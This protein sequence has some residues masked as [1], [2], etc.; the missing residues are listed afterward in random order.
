MSASAASLF[1]LCLGACDVT[2][3]TD[4]QKTSDALRKSDVGT[5]LGR[6]LFDPSQNLNLSPTSI[7]STLRT[8]GINVPKSVQVSA[9]TAQIVMA[10]GAFANAAEAGASIGA[11]VSPT[12]LAMNAAVD[13]LGAVGLMDPKSPGAGL[14]RLGL[15]ALMVISSGGMNIFADIAFAVDVVS[16]LFFPPDGRPAEHAK[17]QALVREDA[18]RWINNREKMQYGQIGQIYHEYQTGSLSTF[19]MI[20]KIGDAAPDLFLNYFPDF[21]TFVPPVQYSVVFTESGNASHGGFVGIGTSTDRITEEYDLVFNSIGK[22]SKSD[23]K[24][25]FIEKYI[26]VP[27]APYRFLAGLTVNDLKNYGYP[28]FARGLGVFDHKHPVARIQLSDLAILS[29]FPPYFQY[30]HD[31]FD[32][33]PYLVGLGLTPHDMGYNVVQRHVGLGDFGGFRLPEPPA[34]TFNGVDYLTAPEQDYNAAASQNNYLVQKALDADRTGD[35]KGL[36]TLPA[37]ERVV[38]EWGIMPYVPGSM[39]NKL[40][41][42]YKTL[43][44]KNSL[45]QYQQYVNKQVVAQYNT[46]TNPNGYRNIR[47]FWSAIALADKMRSDSFFDPTDF[48]GVDTYLTTIDA[49]TQRHK[50]LTGL[51]AARS[52][53]AK[54][55]ANIAGFFGTDPSNIN[56]L[57][58]G[59]GQLASVDTSKI[60]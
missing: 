21:K 18:S 39:E 51:S 3:Q 6:S 29:L 24:H 57:P 10:G 43:D 34:I 56:F 44:P 53:N 41:E 48:K 32:I 33:K 26:A 52:L 15:E 8:L 12:A 27:F 36:L 50:Y 22:Y 49:I 17:L 23:W 14:L 2:K 60:H 1:Y 25:V 4:L 11:F 42:A 46:R 19:A 54:A 55:K 30:V 59:R 9:D 47:N 16:N 38:T 31:A 58:A 40:P 35:I 45:Y 5:K 37:A 13:L 20:A 28:F 7:T